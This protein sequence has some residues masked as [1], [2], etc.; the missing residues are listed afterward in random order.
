[1]CIRR[2]TACRLIAT[3]CSFLAIAFLHAERLGE[4]RLS[5]P[6]LLVFAIASVILSVLVGERA[7][8]ESER[9]ELYGAV[10]IE[11]E[12]LETILDS[13]HIGIGFLDSNLRFL[14]VN[15]ALAE[16]NGLPVREHLGRRILEVAPWTPEPVLEVL[17]DALEGDAAIGLEVAIENPQFGSDSRH[18]VASFLPIRGRSSDVV[19]VGLTVNDVTLI[20]QNEF[21][22]AELRER[23]QDAQ[24]AADAANHMKDEFLITLAHEM[25]SP[26]QAIL[27]WGSL[28]RGGRL[29]ANRPTRHS[30]RSSAS[31]GSRPSS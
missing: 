27:G 12:R 6:N 8:I 2:R 20:K 5:D 10:A 21:I 1:M 9:D 31:C 4:L 3:A 18:F 25:R 7:R 17:R 19:G 28:L 26:L 22:Q 11:R 24:R 30:R 14:Q 16:M 15:E 29:D 23:A 13:A